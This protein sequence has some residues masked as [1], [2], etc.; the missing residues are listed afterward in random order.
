MKIDED[1]SR[2]YQQFVLF[3]HQ[4]VAQTRDGDPQF[5]PWHQVGAL[6]A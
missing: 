3:F 1:N 2:A 6:L 4:R 5:L